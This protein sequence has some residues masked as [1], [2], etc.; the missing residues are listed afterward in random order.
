MPGGLS[1]LE[2]NEFA[3]GLRGRPMLFQAG[4]KHTKLLSRV[5]AKLG[6]VMVDRRQHATEIWG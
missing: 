4:H 6:F 1:V 2:R 5:S 3:S